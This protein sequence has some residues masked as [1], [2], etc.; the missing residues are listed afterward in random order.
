M[1]FAEERLQCFNWTIL[2][3]EYA[4]FSS[5]SELP[6]WFKASTQ[7][8][9]ATTMVCSGNSMFRSL[10]YRCV[11][12]S[13]Y[14]YV[15]TE[16]I[17]NRLHAWMC[18]ALPVDCDST[19]RN[20]ICLFASV[21]TKRG[22]ST[23]VDQQK[24][25]VVSTLRRSSRGRAQEVAPTV[26]IDL[27]RGG[28]LYVLDRKRKPKVPQEQL[29]LS[30]QVTM[31]IVQEALT[32]AL[33]P[34]AVDHHADDDEEDASQHGEE[35]ILRLRSSILSTLGMVITSCSSSFSSFL[36]R[37]T[38]FFSSVSL[39]AV[40]H[41]EPA[42]DISNEEEGVVVLVA[43]HGIAATEFGGATVPLVVITNGAIPHHG[44]N[45]REDPLVVEEGEERDDNDNSGNRMLWER[46]RPLHDPAG[47][48]DPVTRR[49]ANEVGEAFRALVPVSFV[50]GSYA[51]A[52][53]YV[54]A[55]A[56]DKGKKAAVA[57]GDNPGKTTR[58]AVAV[59]DTFVW[60]AL[61]SV[62]IPGFTINRVC[63][64]SLY[65]LGKST[66]WPLPVR[67][68][69]TTAI[70]LST[71][72]FIITPIDRLAQNVCVSS[73]YLDHVYI[74]DNKLSLTAFFTICNL[75]AEL[76]PH[77]APIPS[78][79]PTQFLQ[80]SSPVFVNGRWITQ[81]DIEEYYG[82][83]EHTA[84]PDESVLPDNSSE[85]GLL[86]L[87]IFNL[88]TTP[89]SSLLLGEVHT[90]GQLVNTSPAHRGINMQQSMTKTQAD[91]E[92]LG[93]KIESLKGRSSDCMC[94]VIVLLKREHVLQTQVLCSVGYAFFQ[95]CVIFRKVFPQHA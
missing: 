64:A 56:V 13:P 76:P 22:T 1:T 9:P 86:P 95:D 52:T 3:H 36:L 62:M 71:I 30:A 2:S 12:V 4:R 10:R 74:A 40:S 88:Q 6:H 69:T 47:S 42:A 11:M 68:W 27:L 60:Q 70:G 73:S 90:K 77:R 82:D 17:R 34:V 46:P 93:W 48:S 25:F 39:S 80:T 83:E 24:A 78:Y 67:K 49:Y 72:P 91:M 21:P 31:V 19:L 18:G 85:D 38:A 16:N 29:R 20:C 26:D 75:Q 15:H 57:H 14:T 94:G 45:K 50:W 59:V 84:I 7:Y 79:S 58:V 5:N 53:A 81:L 33:V 23:H 51:V 41:R 92:A 28:T 44:N 43:H 35:H 8:D 32:S 89:E 66:K 37:N 61:A 55:D 87:E 54:T 65:L 63:A